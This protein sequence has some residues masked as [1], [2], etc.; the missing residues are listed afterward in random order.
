MIESLNKV[1]AKLKQL[2]KSQQEKFAQEML[3]KLEDLTSLSKSIREEKLSEALLLPE[4][5]DNESLFERDKDTGKE[6]IL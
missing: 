1:I 4:L 2:S 6:I 5:E 3:E